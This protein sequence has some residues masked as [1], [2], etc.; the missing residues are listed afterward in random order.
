MCD[1]CRRHEA[2]YGLPA[3]ADDVPHDRMRIAFAGLE[4]REPTVRIR[5]RHT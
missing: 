5:I 3:V 2:D 1:S 4:G